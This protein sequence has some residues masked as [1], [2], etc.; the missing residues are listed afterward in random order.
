MIPAIPTGTVESA[1][2]ASAVGRLDSDAFLQLMVAQM[3]YQNPLAPSDTGAMLQQTAAFTQVERL[4]EIAGTQQQLL[5]SQLA[6]AASALVGRHVAAEQPDGTAVDGEV[7]GVRF[8]T[9]G[10]VLQVG[11]QDVA[12]TDVTGVR[13]SA[14][15]QSPPATA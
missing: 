9:D 13:P 2:S 11:D 1:Q 5:G 15:P 7:A 6:A 10:P 14:P 3:R 12:L 8:T 4:Q